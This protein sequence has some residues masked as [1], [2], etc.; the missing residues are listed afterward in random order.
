MIGKAGIQPRRQFNRRREAAGQE[1]TKDRNPQPGPQLIGH[2]F[3]RP[4]RSGLLFWR[5]GHDRGGG[6]QQRA[7]RAKAQQHHQTPGLPLLSAE[8]EHRQTDKAERAQA[9]AAGRHDPQP[10]TPHQYPGNR[11]AKAAGDHHRQHKHP[12]L[13]RGEA[14]DE[15]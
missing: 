2:G 15:L 13:K 12:R 9:H 4:G 8:I 14:V 7:R 5:G 3:N 11:A 1:Q 6:G 10:Q